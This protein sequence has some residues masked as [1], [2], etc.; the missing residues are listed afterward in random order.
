MLVAALLVINFPAA[1]FYALSAINLMGQSTIEVFNDSGQRIDSF[2]MTGPGID[3]E[4]GPIEAGEMTRY[5]VDFQD[6]GTLAFTARQQDVRFEGMLSEY[7]ANGTIGTLTARVQPGGKFEVE[8]NL[9][10]D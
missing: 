10:L 7:I 1:A 4:A 6:E 9:W 3:I 5:F 8:D 2:R